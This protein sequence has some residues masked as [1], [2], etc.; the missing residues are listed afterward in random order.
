MIIDKVKLADE[1]N[2][3][4]QM[5]SSLEDRQI[6]AMK[7]WQIAA[8][9]NC[10]HSCYRV[11]WAYATGTFGLKTNKK[12]A[13]FYFKKAEAGGNFAATSYLNNL[14][15]NPSMPCNFLGYSY[16]IIS[17]ESPK[18]KFF[19]TFGLEL[20]RVRR[21][22]AIHNGLDLLNGLTFKWSDLW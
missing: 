10:Y 21:T 3:E 12:L 20:S 5:I 17:N 15:T 19:Y 6:L 2:N 13:E 16:V 7:I 1:T 11:G 9:D 14:V 4:C 22:H 18:N 8:N